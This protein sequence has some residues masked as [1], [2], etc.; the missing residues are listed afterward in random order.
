MEAIGGEGI[1]SFRGGSPGQLVIYPYPCWLSADASQKWEAL[2]VEEA[3]L[4]V[5][6]QLAIIDLINAIENDRK[7]LSSAEDAVAALEMIVGA[8]ESQLTR[9]RVNFPMENRAHPL[10]RD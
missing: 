3:S 7:P 10:T 4:R 5:G 1:I 6:N 8:Y 9:K 2:G